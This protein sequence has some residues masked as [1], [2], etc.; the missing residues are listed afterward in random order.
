MSLVTTGAET[1][2]PHTHRHHH[3]GGTIWLWGPDVSNSSGS[4]SVSAPAEI[5]TY[6]FLFWA[7]SGTMGGD[8]TYPPGQTSP[9]PAPSFAPG[10]D[11][12]S[13]IAWYIGRGGNG[14]P[15]GLVFDA[16]NAS[17]DDWID[18]DHTNDPFTVT[19]GTR[20]PGPDDDDEVVTDVAV[21]TVRAAP[22]FPG[23]SLAFDHWIVFGSHTH[24]DGVDT[25]Q[26]SQD[27]STSGYAIAVYSEPTH[28]RGPG[29]QYYAYD[30]WWWLKNSP[31]ELVGQVM[32]QQGEAAQVATLIDASA[33]ITSPRARTMVQHALYETLI[34]VAHEHLNQQSL[35]KA[36][37]AVAKAK[38]AA[39]R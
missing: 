8:L 36:T 26:V 34:S 35:A 39:A 27:E 16:F 31:V 29:R 30:P 19:S 12:G 4:D 32:R 33:A 38:A 14:G 18:W 20:L 17:A 37:P 24:V 22:W 5:G 21:A 15:P 2:V 3:S 13:V 11:P 25:E 7:A 9:A 28:V 10:T 6:E 1:W 23:T